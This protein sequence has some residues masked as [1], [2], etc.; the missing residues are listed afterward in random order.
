MVIHKESFNVILRRT[1]FKQY[2]KNENL[3]FL[4]ADYIELEK[5]FLEDVFLFEIDSHFE[6][7]KI[8]DVIGQAVREEIF[9]SLETNPLL[10]YIH[11][12]NLNEV[13]SM[14]V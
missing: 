8:L 5:S 6:D 11:M 9:I 4:L 7:N 13:T 14:I 12:I 3:L 2:Y 1:Y 10:K